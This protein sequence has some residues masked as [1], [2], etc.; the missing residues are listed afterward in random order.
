MSEMISEITGIDGAK[1]ILYTDHLV[2]D[3]TKS[4][5]ITFTA[6]GVNAPDKICKTILFRDISS[7]E[8]KEASKK[9]FV[10]VNGM[11][12]VVLKGTSIPVTASTAERNLDPNLIQFTPEYNDA[13]RTMRDYIEV[14][15]QRATAAEASVPQPSAADEIKK[16]KELLDSGIITQEEFDA[17]KKQLLGI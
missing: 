7:I 12:R 2:I 5:S 16:F 15:I 1:A 10:I 11:F 14:E 13:A 9:M 3:R 8:F 17:K 6:K 4:A